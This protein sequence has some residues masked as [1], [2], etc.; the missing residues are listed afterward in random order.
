MHRLALIS[1]SAT[2]ALLASGAAAVTWPG[3]GHQYDVIVASGIEWSAAAAAETLGIGWHLAT[4]TSA[5]EDAFVAS[6]IQGSGQLWLGGFQNPATTVDPNA[7]WSWITGEPWQ[8]IAW[9]SPEPN[10]FYGPASEQHLA[11]MDGVWNDEGSSPRIAGYVIETPI[12]VPEPATLALLGA[13]LGAC[14]S[15]RRADAGKR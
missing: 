6:I 7:N 9:R 13:G 10:D 15:R 4:I 12:P 1:A 11:I 3:N 8:Y 5:E 2:A 14:A